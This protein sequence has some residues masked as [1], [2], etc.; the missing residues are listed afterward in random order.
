MA[1]PFTAANLWEI[2]DAVL[3]Q[4]QAKP[5]K[6]AVKR[7]AATLNRIHNVFNFAKQIGNNSKVTADRVS[8]ALEIL[9][10]FF[11]ERKKACCSVSTEI[12]ESEQRLYDQFHDFVR[13][14]EAHDFRLDMDAGLLMPEIDNWRDIVVVVAAAF[15]VAM[16]P[17]KF[18]LSN[19]G[20]V[21]RFVA[22]V[23]PLMT[24]QSP[25]VFNVGKHLKDQARQQ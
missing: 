24:N 23:I 6:E 14:M 13:A 5:S 15:K 1:A 7:L 10:V 12:A 8:E 17:Q 18:G 9:E 21:P 3:R 2:L 4:P 20:P 22:K 16:Y 25:S 19:D 11:E